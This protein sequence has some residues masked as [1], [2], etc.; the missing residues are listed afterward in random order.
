MINIE[1]FRAFALSFPETAEASHFA[2]TSFK[3]KNK[4][5]ATLNAPEKRATVRFSEIDQDVFCKI[6][7]EIIYRVPNKWSKYGWTHLNL[8]KISEELLLDALTAAYCTV[9]PE[10]LSRLYMGEE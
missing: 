4:V 6:D 10:R 7:P 3:V 5:F 9:A 2:I 8:E 1:T